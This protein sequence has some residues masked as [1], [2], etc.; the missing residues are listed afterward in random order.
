MN[1]KSSI[2]FSPS[3]PPMLN[4]SRDIQNAKQNMKKIK[5]MMVAVTASWCGAC[6]NISAD[7]NKAIR[8]P[9]NTVPATRIDEKLLNQFNRVLKTPIEPPHFPYFIVI[10]EQGKLKEVLETMD[11]VKQ[12][13]KNSRSS[14]PATENPTNSS[15]PVNSIVPSYVPSATVESESDSES[16]SDEEAEEAAL[17]KKFESISISPDLTL[18]NLSANTANTANTAPMGASSAG[19]QI[20]SAIRPSPTKMRPVSGMPTVAKG[21][22]ALPPNSIMSS[23]IPPP[24]E[25]DA[26]PITS[27][28]TS[29][30]KNS[31]RN[32]TGGCLYS[33]IANVAYQLAA[34]ATLLGIA[35]ATLQ[36]RRGKKSKSKRRVRKI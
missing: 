36:K 15:S 27:I 30:N 18:A 4:N 2:G 11:A 23:A 29:S 1:I 6:H 34:P 13:L 19:N 7:L 12:F 20:N 21:P 32:Q 33:S 26:L 24:S 14:S 17:S 31:L 3:I 22:S 35:A 28:T 8:D 5:N 9:N 10:D 25:I 16:D